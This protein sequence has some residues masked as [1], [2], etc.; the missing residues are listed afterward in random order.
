MKILFLCL[1]L[2][3][4]AGCATFQEMQTTV[5]GRLSAGQKLTYAKTE[6]EQGRTNAASAAL[7]SLVEESAYPGITDE[8][9]YR[10]AILKLNHEDKDGS[11]AASRYL[12]RLRR[13]YRDSDWAQQ[14][15]P[16]LDFLNTVAEIKKQNRT[17]KNTNNTLSKENRELHQNIE[18]LKDLDIQLDRKAR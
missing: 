11:P 18:R 10:L 1:L 15:K 14:A 4:S 5:T 6:L 16:L 2:L 12:E 13:D 17:L 8:A 7:E 9:L 3:T